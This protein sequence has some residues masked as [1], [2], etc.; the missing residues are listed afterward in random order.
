[1]ASRAHHAN[2]ARHPNQEAY[3]EIALPANHLSQAGVVL[4][5]L[6]VLF[7]L[8]A[9]LA[10]VVRSANTRFQAANANAQI[11]IFS[12][13][14]KIVCLAHPYVLSTAHALHVVADK[15]Q[16]KDTHVIARPDYI[17]IVLKSVYLVRLIGRLWPAE[18]VKLVQKVSFRYLENNVHAKQANTN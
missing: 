3:V 16:E 17:S 12:M 14:K 18:I 15:C 10:K 7:H 5:V 2:L 4:I 9:G 8:A 6:R 13:Q 1:M 11:L